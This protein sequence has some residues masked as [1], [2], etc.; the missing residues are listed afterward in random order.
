MTPLLN[1]PLEVLLQITSY[2]TTPDY[3]NFRGACKKLEADLFGAFAKEFFSKRQFALVEFSIQALVDISKS[4]LGPY[5]KHVI[6]SLQHPQYIPDRSTDAEHAVQHNHYHA[7]FLSHRDLTNTG[8][9][10]EMLSEAFKHLPNLERY[11]SKPA[12]PL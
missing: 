3:G 8:L 12:V 1:I 5:L 11:V 7:E 10:V 2:L 4:R 9:D 6:I